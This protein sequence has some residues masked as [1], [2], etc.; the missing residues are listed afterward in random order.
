MTEERRPRD[1]ALLLLAIGVGPPRL[2]ARDQQADHAG[3]ELLRKV[4]DL[5][6]SLDPEPEEVETVLAQV[7]NELGEPTG[8]TRA[9]CLGF[10]QEWDACRNA[11]GAWSWLIAEAL[12]AAEAPRK[13]RR[14]RGPETTP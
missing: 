2:R 4:L 8:P 11:P 9:V 13:R 3:G 7:V 12:E 14:E 10:R 5:V 6:I 1:L